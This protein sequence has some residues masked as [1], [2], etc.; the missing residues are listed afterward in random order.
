MGDQPFS[1]NKKPKIRA[2]SNMI[3][4]DA[5]G[6]ASP[7]DRRVEA[8]TIEEFFEDATRFKL[9]PEFLLAFIDVSMS[10]LIFYLIFP[11]VE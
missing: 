6:S 5:D 11:C 4:A 9:K 10:I 3:E 1:K 2:D 8:S 7:T